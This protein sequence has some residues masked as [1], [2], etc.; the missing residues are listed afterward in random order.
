MKTTNINTHVKD[1][2]TIREI[3]KKPTFDLQT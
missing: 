1:R 3:K 2:N